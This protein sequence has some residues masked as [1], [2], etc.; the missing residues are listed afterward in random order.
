MPEI[1]SR[2]YFVGV[3]PSAV[4]KQR[5]IAFPK[6]WRLDTDT[7]R[8]QF[9]LFPA[10]N[11]HLYILTEERANRLYDLLA[12][13]SIMDSE[14][15]AAFTELGTLMQVINLDKQGRFTLNQ[16]LAVYTD[17]HDAAEFRGGV[18]YGLLSAPGRPFKPGGD[19][20]S[21]NIIRMIEDSNRHAP[22]A[23]G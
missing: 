20:D 2:R 16:N 1:Q 22:P 21:F 23:Q 6:V 18:W 14:K 12:Q 17:I 5:R 4:D 9:F 13:S 19:D 10:Q 8:T 7:E 3:I 11:G 15:M